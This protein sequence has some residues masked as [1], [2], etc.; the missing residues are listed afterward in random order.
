MYDFEI[1]YIKDSK[2]IEADVVSRK[3]S[4]LFSGSKMSPPCVKTHQNLDDCTVKRCKEV[5]DVIVIQNVK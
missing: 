1:K 5:N 4:I 2:N 3:V